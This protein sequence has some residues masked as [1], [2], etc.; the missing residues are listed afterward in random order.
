M[1]VVILHTEDLERSGTTGAPFERGSDGTVDF[2]FAGSSF[3]AHPAALL[4]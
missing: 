1:P 4:A 2:G 3:F